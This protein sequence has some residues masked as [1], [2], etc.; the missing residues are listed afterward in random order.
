M[1]YPLDLYFGVTVGFFA[2]VATAS[3][4]D[5]FGDAMF[6]KGVARPFF[7]GRHRL[8]HRSFLFRGVPVAY[9]AIAAMVLTGLVKIRWGLFWTGLAGTVLVAVDC[10]VLDMTIDYIRKGRGTGFL[11]HEFVYL[12]VPMYAFTAFLRVVWPLPVL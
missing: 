3:A 4:L 5:K 2:T 8:H 9:L 6:E 7:L 11:R 12:A 10:L 1:G